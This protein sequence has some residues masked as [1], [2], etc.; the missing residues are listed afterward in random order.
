MKKSKKRN[1]YGKP[2][3]SAPASKTKTFLLRYEDISKGTIAQEGP[4]SNESTAKEK[5]SSLLRAGICSWL[6]SYNG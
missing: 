3:G 2:D 6:V 4:F 5:L 1:Y